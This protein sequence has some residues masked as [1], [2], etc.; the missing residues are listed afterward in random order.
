MYLQTGLVLEGP[1][2][3]IKIPLEPG[4]P[5]HGQVVSPD[6]KGI[7]GARVELLRKDET[8][9]AAVGH[10]IDN[11]Q[12]RLGTWKSGIYSLNVVH[13]SFVP[14]T[15][16]KLEIPAVEPV[17][18]RLEPA[19][20]EACCRVWGVVSDQSGLPVRDTDIYLQGEG[21]GLADIG[22]AK[23]DA[24]GMYALGGVKPGR[25]T[26]RFL[27]QDYSSSNLHVREL[28]VATEPSVRADLQFQGD[29]T[30]TGIV[31]TQPRDPRKPRR[32]EN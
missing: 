26:L 18:I 10:T 16:I 5:V 24:N 4:F 28:E 11:G 29:H 20:E 17:V 3:Q 27:S 6:S 1:V 2:A 21:K 30:V 13:P 23:T 8:K 19:A 7:G 31:V 32:I 12:F 22:Y 9:P 15:P 14:R 25:Y